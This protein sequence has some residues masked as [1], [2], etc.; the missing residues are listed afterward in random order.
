MN[1]SF[2]SGLLLILLLGILILYLNQ[3]TSHPRYI[4][5]IS[6]FIPYMINMNKCSSMPIHHTGPI[7]NF[8]QRFKCYMPELGWRE[9][10]LNNFNT[11]QVDYTD[12]F[13]GTIV[14]NFL[15]NMDS[16]DNLYKKSC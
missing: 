6:K 10:Y 5:S 3:L 7:Y 14:R 12:S 13:A 4:E 15:D 8:H 1:I 16:V 11:N 9:Y 2:L